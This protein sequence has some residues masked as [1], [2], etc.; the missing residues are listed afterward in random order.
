[1]HFRIFFLTQGKDNYFSLVNLKAAPGANRAALFIN[2]QNMK[3][4]TGPVYK[5]LMEILKEKYPEIYTKADATIISIPDD[6]KKANT[7]FTASQLNKDEE[8]IIM[9]IIKSI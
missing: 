2:N 1:M 7:I 3:E 4:I 5:R 9:G 6:Y 8:N